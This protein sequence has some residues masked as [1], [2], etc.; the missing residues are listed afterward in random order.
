MVTQGAAAHVQVAFFDQW[1]SK[2]FLSDGVEM[3]VNGWFT[4]RFDVP[5][6]YRGYSGGWHAVRDKMQ[7]VGVCLQHHG[8]D[9]RWHNGT[10]GD[11]AP[12]TMDAAYWGLKI[13]QVPTC[14]IEM[15]DRRWGGDKL[16]YKL[17]VFQWTIP[18]VQT[19]PNSKSIGIPASSPTRIRAS[20]MKTATSGSPSPT[21]PRRW[22]NSPRSTTGTLASSAA[23]SAGKK[24]ASSPVPVPAS[25]AR[26]HTSW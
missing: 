26:C 8:G 6:G 18:N 22:R 17:E 7:S 23:S 24:A 9:R 5:P 2:Y 19:C 20:R 12:H 3:M 21:C 10:L 15:L 4:Q 13:D 11:W 1:H 16:H 25:T 14:K